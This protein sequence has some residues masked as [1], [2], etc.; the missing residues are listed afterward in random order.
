M[1]EE[2]ARSQS[3]QKTGLNFAES[4]CQMPAA[5][6]GKTKRVNLLHAAAPGRARYEIPSLYRSERAANWVTRAATE[7]GGVHLARA[8]ALTGT[9]LVEYSPRI[10]SEKK[11]R[12]RLS[13]LVRE[14]KKSKF[15]L[16]PEQKQITPWATLSIEK[17]ISMTR[18]DPKK[19][20]TRLQV[21]RAR[22]LH[23]PNRFRPPAPRSK[24]A[25]LFHQFE[26]FPT[27]LLLGSAAISLATGGILDA[28]FIAGVVLLNSGVG[29]WMEL[30]TEKT[31]TALTKR[32]RF[33][34][35][36]IRGGQEIRIPFED[37]VVGDHLV[38]RAGE[39]VAADAKL[40]RADH[41]SVDESI[42]TGESLP[43]DKSSTRQDSTSLVYRGTFVSGG[44]GIAI[45][46]AVGR[47]TE[48]GRIQN[49]METQVQPSTPMQ[50]QLD[51]LSNQLVVGSLL[52]SGGVLAV[53]L[54][55]GRPF[56]ELLK[57][58]VSL[59]VAA[60]PESLPTVATLTLARGVTHLESDGILVRRLDAVE[61]L[62][63]VDTVCFDKTG[64]LTHNRM[65]AR[66]IQTL[67]NSF[68]PM[69]SRPW[70]RDPAIRQILE[71]GTL[72]NEAILV[73]P[74]ERLSLG[75]SS[76]ERSLLQLARAG[77]IDPEKYQKNHPR[78]RIVHRA[79]GRNYMITE[80]Q[81][82]TIRVAVKG[83]PEEVLA[84]CAQYR[85]AG[86]LAPLSAEVRKRILAQNDAMAS[87]QLR[88][89][90]FATGPSEK[91]LVWLGLVG[92]KD[93][94]RA[95]VNTLV[96]KLHS[97]GLDTYMITGD[98]ESTAQAIGKSIGIQ[99]SIGRVSPARKLEIVQDL[100]K[101]GRVVAMIGDGVNDGPALRTSDIGIAMAA[102]GT[103]VASQAADILLPTDNLG[104]VI[105]AIREGRTVHQDIHKA[106]DYIVAQNLSEM[107]FTFASVAFGNAPPLSSL[108]FLWVNLITDIFPELALAQEPPEKDVLE[109]GP[110][111]REEKILPKRDIG[112]ALLESGALAAAPLGA[113][114]YSRLQGKRE[115]EANSLAFLTLTSSS[116]FYT[117]SARSKTLSL[118]DR[119]KLARNKYIGLSIG[120]GFVAEILSLL[121]PALRGALNY[122]GVRKRD[123]IASTAISAVPMF[124]IEASKFVRR[125][126]A[127]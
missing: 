127:A 67:E 9:L 81:G 12:G 53:G 126:M 42:L 58:S 120:T 92:M 124:A 22:K 14:G 70:P 26:N 15:K 21:G 38:L 34:S 99:R 7:L 103:E 75:G 56:L 125:R 112:K 60:I 51:H 91:K 104:A 88:V 24:G 18:T 83:S 31:I 86:K 33:Q 94:I 62:A 48:I 1:L 97:A 46:V 118:F 84:L 90:G 121:I 100:Q 106:V 3:I 40:L 122:R 74:A 4:P 82:K 96:E 71:V 116:L 35:R 73:D 64:T 77:G 5:T 27:A 98:Q 105:H 108:Q 39:R 76:T 37:V 30:S 61:T 85:H 59:A 17:V 54:L 23:G 72:C 68:D 102:R 123:L 25:I 43:V 6:E 93:P 63:S 78:T 11:L 107:M 8:N 109:R 110:H 20:L 95:G 41:L 66:R 117:L 101:S 10:F 114:L 55:R 50:Q 49:L 13:Q 89:L 29:Y 69:A 113:Y 16:A 47:N 45:V 28:A 36:V 115:A 79:E 32:A 57:T 52:A 119:E 19:G 80:H 65:E 44:S 111:G 2:H 87:G